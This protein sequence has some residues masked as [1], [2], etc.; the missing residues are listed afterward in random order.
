MQILTCSKCGL[1]KPEGEFSLRRGTVRGRK[2]HCKVC[3]K[4]RNDGLAETRSI[5]NKERYKENPQFFINKTQSWRKENPGDWKNISSRAS[6][7]SNE[8]HPNERAARI[9]VGNALRD[10]K[11]DPQPCFTCGSTKVEAHHASYSSDMKLCVTWLCREHHRE[12]H[13]SFNSGDLS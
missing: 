1:D 4:I 5:K 10:G 12:I 2:S 13:R 9:A 7:R 8:T 6:S 11:I 3:V